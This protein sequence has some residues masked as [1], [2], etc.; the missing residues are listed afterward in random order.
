VT[1][2]TARR[3]SPIAGFALILVALIVSGFAYSAVSGISGTADAAE[4]GATSSQIEAGKQL[5]LESC[6]SCHG[7]AAEGTSNGPT[8]IGVG[9]AAVDFQVGTGRMPAAYPTSGQVPKKRVS[10]ND[11]QVAA[12][13][14]YVAS[15]A[16][17]PAIPTEEEL[18]YS[19]ADLALGG[20]LFRT[21]C[22]QCHN[23]AA[24]GGALSNGGYAPNLTQVS[25][26]HIYEAML[27]GPQNMP[28]FGNG[29]LRVEDKQAIIKYVR[30]LAD[31]PNPGGAS[32]GK[33]GPVTEGLVGWLV[34]LGALIGAAVWIGVKAS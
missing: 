26:K 3:R 33:V 22:A 11:E 30:S 21:N 12:L 31:E 27:T 29:T 32:L 25:A 18:D 24:Q 28:V 1:R 13:S 20:E 23:F 14:A 6:S 19:D 15:L 34:G 9:A 5:F 17:G 7:L 16:P 4:S 10:F 2:T 8:L